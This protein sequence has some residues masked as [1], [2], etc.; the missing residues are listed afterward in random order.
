MF[1]NFPRASQMTQVTVFT[2]FLG[3]GKTTIILDILKQLPKD[4]KVCLLKNEFGDSQTDSLLAQE[5]NV[6]ITE[7]SN[8]CL[9]CVL[10][11]RMAD[12][13]LELKEKYQP[14]RIIVETSGSAFPAPIAW[15]IRKLDGFYLD[16][17]ITVIDCVNF[18]GYEDTSYTARM[19]AQYTDIILL[20]KSDLVSERELDLLIDK[21][22]ELNCDTPKLKWTPNMSYQQLF[23]IDTQLFLL[24]TNEEHD[25]D[26]HREIE[27]LTIHSPSLPLDHIKAFLDTVKKERVYRI[28]GTISDSAT[29]ILNWAF[30]RWQ[31]T[32]TKKSIDGIHLTVMGQELVH[33]LE[34]FKKIFGEEVT[35]HR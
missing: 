35:L 5:S 32:P 20:N 18:T 7:I 4:Y 34:R 1:L 10:V 29:Y 13:L 26:H 27:L 11:G 6:E 3:A 31:L 16:A 23:G 30:E 15:Q 12:A 25:K 24:Q 14:E 2:G 28:K 19:Q 9:C 17:I 8:G 21:V 22:D 33:E